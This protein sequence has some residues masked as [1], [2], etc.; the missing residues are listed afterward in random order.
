[1]KI[2]NVYIGGWFQRT[3]L[4]LSEVYDFLRG[5]GGLDKLSKKKMAEL[6]EA[7][8]IVDL[9]YGV[10]GEEYLKFASKDGI[11]VKIFEDG[12]ITLNNPKIETRTLASDIQKVQD[13]YEKKL[14]PAINYLFSLG[15]PVPKELA[16]IENV[17]PYFIVLDKASK[18]EMEALLEQTDR[19]KYFEFNNDK[20]DVLRG[21]KYYYINIG[22]AHFCG[23][24]F[25]KIYE[26]DESEDKR[27]SFSRA[28]RCF[29]GT[30]ELTNYK[31][32]AYYTGAETVWR[33]IERHIDDPR[34]FDHLFIDFA[35]TSIENV[36]KKGLYEVNPL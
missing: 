28:M 29:R 24:D 16:N 30:G 13:Y 12:L 1:M 7:L 31:D 36:K 9:Q 33:Y 3:M 6:R 20:Y 32:L 11:T 25:R 4:Q 19:Q 26:F 21:D 17:Y 27:L 35:A 15:A 2:S 5:T 14:S 8:D 10:S 18:K 22:L 23:W 34:L